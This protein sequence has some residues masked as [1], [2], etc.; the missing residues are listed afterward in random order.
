MKKTEMTREMTRDELIAFAMKRIDAKLNHFVR[1]GRIRECDADDARQDAIVAVLE[2]F[3]EY[4]ENREAVQKTFISAIV[5]NAFKYYFANRKVVKN[6]EWA[7]IDS[8]PESKEPVINEGVLGELTELDRIYMKLDLATVREKLSEKQ[9]AVFDLMGTHSST[10]IATILGVSVRT[11]C[12]RIDVIRR[13]AKRLLGEE[14][15]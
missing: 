12:D 10:D 8:L 7:D 11:V 4:D 15:I 3:K 6:R 5:R 1:E 13:T 14:E 9:Q 2:K